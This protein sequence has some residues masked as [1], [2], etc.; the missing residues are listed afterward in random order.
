MDFNGITGHSNITE[1]L[2]ASILHSRINHAYIFD[3]IKGV[4]K[5]TVAKAFAKALN[6]EKGNIDACNNCISCKTFEE[7]NNPDIIYVTHSKKD[8]TVSDVREQILSNI[9][10][11]PYRNRYKIF[12]IPDADKM[13]V[14]AQN[15]FLKTLEE[16]PEYGIFLLLSENYNKFLV[17]ILSRCI[18]FRLHPLP[19]KDVEKYLTTNYNIPSDT[20]GIYSA[21][22]QGSIGRA[23]ELIDSEE[24]HDTLD[25]AWEYALKAEEADLTELYAITDSLREHKNT[26]DSILEIMY[27]IYRDALVYKETTLYKQLIQK[28]RLENIKKIALKTSSAQLINRCSA[29]DKARYRL[30]RNGNSQLILETLFFNIKER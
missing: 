10:V 19:Y 14:L 22:S 3:G 29:I 15:A 17:T 6:C 30:S 27:L 5:L 25:R 8:I 18:L 12:I 7:N 21:Y 16:P 28:D 20:A 2:Q 11:K 24:F 4:G 23:V 26:I 9:S 1:H 13:N